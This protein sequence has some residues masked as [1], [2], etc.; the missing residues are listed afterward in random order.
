MPTEWLQLLHWKGLSTRAKRKLVTALGSPAAVVQASDATIRAILADKNKRRKTPRKTL[1]IVRDYPNAAEDMEILARLGADFIGFN[2][3]DFPPLLNQ[4]HNPPLGLFV[5]GARELLRRPQ[6][7]I[8]GSR[9]PTLAGRRTTE[10]LAGELT[11]RGFAVTSGL[12]RGIDSCAH[13]GCL[14]A[15]GPTIGVVAAGLDRVYPPANAELFAEIAAHGLLVGEFPPGTPP[16]R[17]HFP[18]RNRIISGLACGV[19]VVEAG[20]RSGSLITA[21]LAMEENREVFAVPGSIYSAVSR[22][23]HQLLRH[24]AKLVESVDDIM[25]ELGQFCEA[26]VAA[27]TVTD[28]AAVAAKSTPAAAAITKL[29]VAKNADT[30]RNLP[31]P[32]DLAPLYELIGFE[33][34]G[35]DE[36][37][38][39]S[40]W[41]ADQVSHALT[42]LEL[43]GWITAVPGGYQ[44]RPA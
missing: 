25:E 14:G 19:L 16:R 40:G 13:R 5:L 1:R 15:G 36:L 21:R 37:I 27:D 29:A 4:I 35:M 9:S 39:R 2:A 8:V 3:D 30:A 31:P 26:P 11:A 33:D 7:A 22:G 38:A 18:R 6:I 24:G 32:A 10:Q 17:E 23:C 42:L 41:R 43:G 20:I 12:A 34:V 44:R 28:S